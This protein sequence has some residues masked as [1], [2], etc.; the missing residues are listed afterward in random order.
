MEDQ[1]QSTCTIP[2]LP[3]QPLNLAY[4]SD[5]L[6]KDEDRRAAG[7]LFCDARHFGAFSRHTPNPKAKL[8]I[9]QADIGD[10]T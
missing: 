5:K 2:S 8:F 1:S 7:A 9:M 6:I 10:N 4:Y 3:K